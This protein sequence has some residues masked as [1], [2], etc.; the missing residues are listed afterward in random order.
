MGKHPVRSKSAS[1]PNSHPGVYYVKRSQFIVYL[2]RIITKYTLFPF[3]CVDDMRVLLK[4]SW[5]VELSVGARK[6]KI[7]DILW[8]THETKAMH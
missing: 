3:H 5:K 7:I 1:F 6:F 4:S 8:K 2:P